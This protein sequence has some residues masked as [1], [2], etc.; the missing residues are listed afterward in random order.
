MKNR[1]FNI[2]N[3]HIGQKKEIK[4]HISIHD[5]IKFSELSGDKNPIHIDENYANNSR[6]KKRLIHGTLILAYFSKIYGMIFPGNGCTIAEQNIIYKKPA[7]IDKTFRLIV[8]IINID[9]KKRNLF[10]KN[11]C[12]D[13]KK[14]LIEGNTRI[15]LP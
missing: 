1:I 2:E 7:Y 8:E 5:V 13:G 10:F 9:K 15:F 6:F 4:E 11:T 3:F 12:Y 14:I